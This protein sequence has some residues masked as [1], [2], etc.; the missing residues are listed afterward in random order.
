M[1]DKIYENNELYPLLIE[2]FIADKIRDNE[3]YDS[4]S[5]HFMELYYVI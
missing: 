4:I 2:K 5:I 1:L 3:G